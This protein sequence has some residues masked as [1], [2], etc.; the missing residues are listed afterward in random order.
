MTEIVNQYKLAIIAPTCFYYQVEL[1]RALSNHP[2]I[3]LTVYFCSEEA[4]HASD[5]RIMYE[6][7]N[8]WGDESDLLYGYN[9]KFIPNRSPSPSYL[10][11]PFGLMNVSIWDEINTSKP[12][13][14]ILMSW[15]NVTWW[16]AIAACLR[17]N[18]PFFYLTD[19]NVQ[20]ELE[21]PTWKKW[22]K[23]SFLGNIVFKLAAGFLCAGTANRMFY[24]FFGVPDRKLV[25][26]AYSWGYASHLQSWD[27]MKSLR[28]KLRKE[29]GIPE[30]SLVILY[31]GRLSEEKNFLD[32]VRA[33]E[34]ISSPN[35]VLNVVGDGPLRETYEAYMDKYGVKSVFF[36][37]F[38]SRKDISNHYATADL[39]VLPSRRETWGM[40][41]NEAMCF[42]LPIISTFQVGAA[43]DLVKDGVNGFVYESGDVDALTKKIQELADMP[44]DERQTIG[45]KSRELIERWVMQD[46]GQSLSQ[47]FDQINSSSRPLPT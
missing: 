34:R 14:V 13:A 8:T 36:R 44:D 43:H 32:L 21:G 20:A 38:Q 2:R 25:P 27:K 39:L 46:L 15:M 1:F 16:I 28:S 11:W 22:L 40:V 6:T 47:Y 29:Q 24:Q 19:A 4:L 23:K 17:H 12:D 9:Y 35:K 45:A 31:C 30:D 7:N 37:G 5:V 3:D 33:Y 41:V 18:V 26:F 42:S 10:K